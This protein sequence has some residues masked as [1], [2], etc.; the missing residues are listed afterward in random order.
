M[1]SHRAC[2][3]AA[4]VSASSSACVPAIGP[5]RLKVAGP[6]GSPARARQEMTRSSRPGGGRPGCPRGGGRLPG[7]GLLGGGGLAGGGWPG[8]WPRDGGERPVVLVLVLVLVVCVPGVP[9]PGVAVAA[10]VVVG[11]GG[12]RWVRVG[13]HRHARRGVAAVVCGRVIAAGGVVGV[14]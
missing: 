6:A 5:I 12:V 2:G 9:V 8:G 3:S 1:T 11:R 13:R 7:G 14:A 4:A 10:L